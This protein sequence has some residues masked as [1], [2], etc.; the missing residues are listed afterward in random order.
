MSA[1]LECPVCGAYAEDTPGGLRAMN[2]HRDVHVWAAQERA[3]AAERQQ[4]ATARRQKLTRLV[5]LCRNA[6]RRHGV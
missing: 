5:R 3:E 4:A 2:L 6:M 1:V